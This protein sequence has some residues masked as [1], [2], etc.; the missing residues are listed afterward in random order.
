MNKTTVKFP[1]NGDVGLGIN[2][3]GAAS[4]DSNDTFANGNK[5]RGFEYRYIAFEVTAEEGE[6]ITRCRRRGY[7]TTSVDEHLC[8]NAPHYS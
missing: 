5:G 2:T 8:P 6:E 7:F 1:S 4:F 3:S